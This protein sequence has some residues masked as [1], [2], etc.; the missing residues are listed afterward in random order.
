MTAEL[1]D[2]QLA[3][4]L[5]AHHDLLDTDLPAMLDVGPAIEKRSPEPKPATARRHP[6]ELICAR[7]NHWAATDSYPA[8][9]EVCRWCIGR[10][11]AHS[12]KRRRSSCR[13]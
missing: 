9:S 8:G 7:C 13:A 11:T 12:P 5:L 10:L 3:W 1:S 6:G 4:R 2:T